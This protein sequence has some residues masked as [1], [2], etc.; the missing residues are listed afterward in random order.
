MNILPDDEFFVVTLKSGKKLGPF[1]ISGL[2]QLVDSGNLSESSV[3]EMPSGVRLFAQDLAQLDFSVVIDPDPKQIDLNARGHKVHILLRWAMF[4]GLCVYTWP[5]AIAMVIWAIVQTELAKQAGLGRK[6]VSRV[7]WWIVVI[8]VL[9]LV[10][11]FMLFAIFYAIVSAQAGS[12]QLNDGR[13][14]LRGVK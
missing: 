5:F 8:F 9:S 1:G 13:Y 14:Q 6:S 10:L 12:P 2:Q 11:G 4:L 3:L 7:Y